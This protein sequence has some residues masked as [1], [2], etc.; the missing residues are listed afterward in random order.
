MYNALKKYAHGSGFVMFCYGLIP[1]DLTNPIQDWFNG[2]R[3]QP[4]KTWHWKL[5]DVMVAVMTTSDATSEEKVLFSKSQF[6]EM[7]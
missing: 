1:V 5:R 2:T 6:T 3:K 7:V 4:W